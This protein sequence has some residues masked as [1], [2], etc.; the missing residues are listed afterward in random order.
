V[1]RLT[2]T[3]EDG[4]GADRDRQKFTSDECETAHFSVF[5]PG[6]VRSVGV[7]CGSPNIGPEP[8]GDLLWRGRSACL[9]RLA[10]SSRTF[11]SS[12]TTM[13]LNYSKW[14]ALEVRI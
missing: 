5:C 2:E 14:D 3:N 8:G 11:L 6:V 12:T 7:E 4:I 1:N 9:T 13:P 10:E